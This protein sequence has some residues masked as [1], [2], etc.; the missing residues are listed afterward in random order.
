MAIGAIWGEIWDAAIW[1]TAIWAQAAAPSNPPVLIAPIPSREFV[2]D[3]AIAAFDTGAY[4]T[5]ATSYALTGTLPAGLSFNTGTGVISGTPTAVETATG[6]YVTATNAD[7]STDSGTFFIRIV[8]EGSG[9]GAGRKSGFG[10][11]FGF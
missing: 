8:A 5:G 10:L 7:G 6:L 1:D 3:A 4:F 2:Q 11:G 9:A